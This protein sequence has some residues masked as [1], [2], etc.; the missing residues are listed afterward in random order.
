MDGPAVERFSVDGRRLSNDALPG[1]LVEKKNYGGDNDR[2]EAVTFSQSEGL[3]AAPEEPLLNRPE[4]IH[5]IFAASGKTWSFLRQK[6]SSLK[7]MEVLPDGNLLI[8]ERLKVAKDTYIDSLR[9][10]D[11]SACG[12]ATVCN[13]S[14]LPILSGE[15]PSDNFEGLARVA[16]DRFVLVP[17]KK[18]DESEPASLLL[19]RAVTSEPMSKA[20]K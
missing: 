20:E 15:F 3:I 16:T 8:L 19:I 11:V 6:G 12:N 17:D 13:V 14:A 4:D 9:T 10:I 7:A 1:P 18:S 5:T 2:I